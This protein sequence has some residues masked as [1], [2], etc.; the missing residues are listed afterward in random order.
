MRDR[1]AS[2]RTSSSC[3]VLGTAL[4]AL[5]VLPVAAGAQAP[6]PVPL[7]TAPS[8]PSLPPISLPVT[9]SSSQPCPGAGRRS[10][11]RARRIA[12]GCLVNKAR[13]SAGLRGFAWSRSLARAA[14]RHARDMARRGYFGHRRSGGPSPARRARSAGWRGRGV[15]EA[16]AYGCGSTSTPASIVRMWLNSSPHRR[17]LLSRRGHVGIGISGRPPFRCGGG[18]ATYVLDAG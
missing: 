2:R 18:G 16:I 12:V 3:A 9:V 14:T 5:L 17:I 8:V 7:P 13:T 4:G 6:L 10:G 11:A 15:G 1:A